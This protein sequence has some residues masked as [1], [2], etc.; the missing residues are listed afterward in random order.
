VIERDL[1]GPAGAEREPAPTTRGA[2]TA[3][4]ARAAADGV[5]LVEARQLRSGYGG[6]PAIRDVDLCLHAGEVVALLGANGA[7]KTTTLLALAGVL[8]PLHGEVVWD[9]RSR[10]VPLHRRAQWGLAFVADER[11]LFSSLSASANLRLGR[12]SPDD[13]VRLFPELRPLLGTRAGLLSGG[14]QRMLALARALSSHPR[15]LFVDELSHGLAPDVVERL[16]AAVRQAADGGVGVLL[17]EQRIP[18]ALEIA[19]RS[20]VLHLGRVVTQQGHAD[21]TAASRGG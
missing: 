19:D 13:A 12:G 6:L 7:G 4:A 18:L 20:Y 8:E 21:A 5:P 11:S 15:V 2:R 10:P 14:E 16:L 17:V 1:G 3:G 9:G